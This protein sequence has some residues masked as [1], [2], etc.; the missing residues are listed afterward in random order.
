MLPLKRSTLPNVLQIIINAVLNWK[1][2]FLFKGQSA[3]SSTKQSPTKIWF[4]PCYL[5]FSSTD[6]EEIFAENPITINAVP[7]SIQSS[8]NKHSAKWSIIWIKLLGPRVQEQKLLSHLQC[9]WI[10]I[11]SQFSL[12]NRSN[13]L[14]LRAFIKSQA[15]DQSLSNSSTAIE[16][17][18]TSSVLNN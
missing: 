8:G 18:G 15:Y 14:H 3:S 13:L 16:R 12:Q 17:Y 4:L 9:A 2:W 10:F 7:I 1:V 11:S 5:G 6:S